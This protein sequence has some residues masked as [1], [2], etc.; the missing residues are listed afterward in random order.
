M[1]STES[2]SDFP[3]ARKAHRT[4]EPMHV[5][6]YFAPETAEAFGE[7]GV[8]GAQAYFGARAA[9]M[10]RVDASVVIAT[11]YNF[12]P[13]VVRNAIPR[14]WDIAPPEALIEARYVGADRAL[15]RIL[16]EDI[17]A[18]DEVAEAAA[19]AREATTAL[20]VEGRALF[21]GYAELAWPQEPHLQLFHAQTLLREHRGDGHVAALTLGGLDPVEALL[22]HLGSADGGGLALPVI[23]ATRGWS[24]EEWAAGQRRLRERGLIDDQDQCTSDGRTLRATIEA[25]TDAAAAAPYDHLG[26]DRTARL[27]ELVKPLAKAVSAQLFGGNR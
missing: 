10:G 22:T 12:A 27:R 4:L 6:A 9:P 24:D 3:L 20:R 15:R 18:S 23:R 7:I 25:H 13:S 11:F 1:S 17:V 8:H 14:I 26:P 5:V 2:A 21:A 19:L 16:G